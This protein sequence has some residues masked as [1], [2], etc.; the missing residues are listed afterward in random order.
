VGMNPSDELALDSAR[1]L[2]RFV[3]AATIATDVLCRAMARRCCMMSCSYT[4]GALLR[5]EE[6]KAVD[7]HRRGQVSR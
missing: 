6:H 3:S 4:V 5:V 7:I 1:S 2:E